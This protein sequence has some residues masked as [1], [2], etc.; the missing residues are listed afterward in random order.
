MTYEEFMAIKNN[1]TGADFERNS[2]LPLN[3]FVIGGVLWFTE[4]ILKR[5]RY[6]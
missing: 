4:K 2:T 6:Y 1:F 3:I 5:T